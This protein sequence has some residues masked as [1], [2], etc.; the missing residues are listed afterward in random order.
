MLA[1]VQDVYGSASSLKIE[2][3]PKPRPQER[4]VVVEVRAAG[5]D[6]G[7]WHLMTGRPYLM[8][9]AG[10]GFSGP[11]HRIIGK[12]FAGVVSTVGSEVKR[13]KPGDAVFGTGIG[14][15]AFS[16]FACINEQFVA[17]KPQGV[18]FEEAAAT[19][20]SALT[21]LH[22]VKVAGRVCAGQSV[23][24]VGASGGVGSFAVQMAHRLGAEVIGVCRGAKA[25]MVRR[26][27]AA[28]TIDYTREDFTAGTNRYDVILD[29]GGNRPLRRLRRVLKPKGTLVLVGGENGG[30]WLGGVDRQL[31]AFLLSLFVGQRLTSFISLPSAEKLEEVRRLLEEGAIRPSIDR[32]FALK[33]VQSALEYLE[34]GRASGKILLQA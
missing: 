26:L 24:I 12:D 29:I 11:K 20:D 1:V 10:L 3:V 25:E 32:T 8:R 13:F 6:R 17:L 28:G 19:P 33:D 21:A 31:R 18:S 23:L 15:G 34:E 7:V 27:G 9:L 22:A 16:E 4:E 30:N 5:L 2:R 14:A